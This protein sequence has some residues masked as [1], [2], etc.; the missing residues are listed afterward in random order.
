M[1]EEDRAIE[2][3]AETVAGLV[4]PES[5][6]EVN[7]EFEMREDLLENS[8]AVREQANACRNLV[9]QKEGGSVLEVDRKY[10]VEYSWIGSKRPRWSTSAGTWGAAV[11]LKYCTIRLCWRA[12]V[13]RREYM[14]YDRLDCL[15]LSGNADVIELKPFI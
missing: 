11:S 10:A 14:S 3:L 12:K 9:L 7:I 8:A 5:C 1:P 4:L 2:H 15:R 13:P 6:Q